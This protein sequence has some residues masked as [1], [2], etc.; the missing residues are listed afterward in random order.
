MTPMK[1]SYS[2]KE[3]KELRQIEWNIIL[4][5]LKLHTEE[6]RFYLQG[7]ELKMKI[8]IVE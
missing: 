2:G 1:C 7:I 5:D 4:E 3:G 8:F 6:R